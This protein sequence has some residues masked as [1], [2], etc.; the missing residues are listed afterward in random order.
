MPV[1][2]DTLWIDTD[3]GLATALWRAAVLVDGADDEAVGRLVVTAEAEG[4]SI[5]PE[6]VDRMLARFAPEVTYVDA[7]SMLGSAPSE[8][9]VIADPI[10]VPDVAAPSPPPV[11]EG[12]PPPAARPTLAPPPPSEAPPALPFRAPAW[13]EP[14]D[15]EVT[16]PRGYPSIS[17]LRLMPAPAPSS[18]DP[19]GA[20]PPPLADADFCAVKRAVWAG[21]PLAAVLEGRDLDE[22]AFRAHEAAEI[23]ALEREAAGGAADCAVALLERLGSAPAE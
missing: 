22:A 2:W 18:R 13:S 5:G 17:A 23:L 10:P 19:L 6:D 4:E 21:E 15:S 14:D 8:A 3:R 9:P 12:T 1:R 7:A 11:A 20:G 16:P